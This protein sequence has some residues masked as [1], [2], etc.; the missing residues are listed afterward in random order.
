MIK[1]TIGEMRRFG[2]STTAKEVSDLNDV[3]T[4]YKINHTYRRVWQFLAQ[5]AEES[6]YG[7]L[8][9]ELYNSIS[10][11]DKYVGR[12]GNRDLADAFK[13]RG[14]GFIQLTGRD[15][16]AAFAKEFHNP[17]ILSIGATHV[18]KYYPWESAA[19]FW[20]NNNLNERVDEGY[21]VRKTTIVVNGGIT[22]YTHL[23]KRIAAYNRIKEIIK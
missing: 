4:K 15:N 14:A 2:F 6:D 16:Y 17:K 21:T 18:A 5:C 9:S 23:D 12:M 10:D 20:H 22:K 11:F 7:S 13:Y 8:R 1:V 3:M 19:F